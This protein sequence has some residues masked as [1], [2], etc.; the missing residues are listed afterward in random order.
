MTLRQLVW[1]VEGKRAED[2]HQVGWIVAHVINAMAGKLVCQVRDLDPYGKPPEVRR[3]A[4]T[5]DDISI[6]GSL[7]LGG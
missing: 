5:T 6:L 2:G 1:M 4:T 7:M 3:Y